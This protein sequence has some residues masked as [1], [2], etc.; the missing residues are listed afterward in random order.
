M[1]ELKAKNI[2]GC[3]TLAV[4]IDQEQK[5]A[6]LYH[7]QTAPI[8]GNWRKASRKQIREI[9]NAYKEN[10]LYTVWEV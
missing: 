8:G 3:T 7:G 4:V 1:I 5:T 2:Y 9:F 10:P 6:T